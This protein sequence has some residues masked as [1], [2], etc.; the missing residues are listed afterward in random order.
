M[1]PTLA[2]IIGLTSTVFLIFAV[3]TKASE[4]S[5]PLSVENCGKSLSFKT[6]PERIVTIG[7]SATGILYS[8]DIGKKVAGTSVWYSEVL[9]E[10][11]KLNAGIERLADNDPSFESVVAKKLGLVAVTFEWH[12]GRK[13]VPGWMVEKLGIRNVIESDEEWPIVG[14]ETIAKANPD[15]IVVA[16][17]IRRNFASRHR[18]AH[19]RSDRRDAYSG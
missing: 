3:H 13:G 14:W 6:A 8:L 16:K 4:T 17:V 15:L 19:W 1:K 12:V 2:S 18:A 9:P 7:Q 5:Y 10:F 11:A